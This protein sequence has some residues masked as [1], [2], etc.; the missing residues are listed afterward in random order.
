MASGRKGLAPL[1]SPLKM[2]G[3]HNQKRRERRA[4]LFLTGFIPLKTIGKSEGRMMSLA[5]FT[6][7]ELLV[8]VLII[9]ITLG[10]SAPLF[11]KTFSNVQLS[12]R[13]EEMTGLMRYARER[14]VVENARTRFNVDAQSGKYWLSKK[15]EDDEAYERLSG[16]YGREYFLGEE[17]KI[18]AQEGGIDFYPDGEISPAE[19]ILINSNKK[20]LTI[21]TKSGLGNAIS[22]IKDESG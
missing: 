5:G 4:L 9:S 2:D 12:L 8:V 7:I 14:A 6:L 1:E 15:K 19:I 13:A 18:E 20:S 10:L 11:R 22:I 21:L 16:Q 3:K 17:I